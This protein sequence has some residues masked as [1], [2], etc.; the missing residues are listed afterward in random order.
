MQE[1][2]NLL[3]K[4]S[5]NFQRFSKLGKGIFEIKGE[6]P[7]AHIA[8]T[9]C[10]H[11]NETVG[12]DIM[13]SAIPHLD[14][15]G[16]SSGKVT[17]ICA[18]IEA[19]RQNVRFV[20]ED[21]N[22]LLGLEGLENLVGNRTNTERA[23]L[24]AILPFFSNCDILLDVHSTI[25]ASKP[26]IFCK[27]SLPHLEIAENFEINT[28]ISPG[29]NFSQEDKDLFTSFDSFIDR[30]GGIGVTIEAGSIE[31]S[32]SKVALDGIMRIIQEKCTIL[33][34]E[35]SLSLTVI[36]A[37]SNT[38]VRDKGVRGAVISLKKGFSGMRKISEK[39]IE[40][41][42]GA[43]DFSVAQFAAE[44]GISG[45]E[46]L[47][48]IPGTIGGNVHMNAGCYGREIS[49]IFTSCE[50]VD[51]AGNIGILHKKD[52]NFTYRSA[53]LP[54]DIIITKVVLEGQSGEC[55]KI[56]KKMKEISEKRAK[57][58]PIGRKTVGSTFKNPKYFS[59]ESMELIQAHFR[60]EFTTTAAGVKKFRIYD[61]IVAKSGNFR[62]AQENI[63]NF[64]LVKSGE[65]FAN[66]GGENISASRDSFVI[67]PKNA[68]QKGEFCCFLAEVNE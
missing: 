5:L 62:F 36:G 38:I 21:M 68:I 64:T 34:A 47:I 45:M 63:A 31:N 30:N 3:E 20:V 8:I 49:D 65:N 26:F 53:N 42:A 46:F 43:L 33:E 9:L 19:I 12:L 1:I 66:D 29:G 24:V 48:G 23:R 58:Q 40:V 41:G 18:N 56:L 52:V 2:D 35:N 50:Y 54:S 60:K 37:R 10:V 57:T 51:F 17:F 28:I 16:I 67:F 4:I 32:C 44:N 14:K 55:E 6:K 15:C 61:K 59:K 7:G 13:Q 39:K 22:R 11:G 27:N 25:R